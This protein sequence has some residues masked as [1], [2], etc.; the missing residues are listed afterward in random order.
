MINNILRALKLKIKDNQDR[1]KID[2]RK[3]TKNFSMK[4]LLELILER[5]KI[6]QICHGKK[7]LEPKMILGN[8][9]YNPESYV[10]LC[11]KCFEK[12]NKPNSLF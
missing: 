3:A 8:E 6:C 7:N 9:H 11:D 12:L 10:V 4:K 2:Y 5:D 1:E